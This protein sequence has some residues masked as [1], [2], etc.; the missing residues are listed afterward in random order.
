MGP[1]IDL[2]TLPVDPDGKYLCANCGGLIATESQRIAIKGEREQS[3]RNPSGY[4]HLIGYFQEASG[5]IAIGEPTAE[6]TWFE[7]Y[8]YVF[9]LCTACGNHLGWHYRKPGKAQFYGLVLNRLRLA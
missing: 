8:E 9:A 4:H 3:F 7:G 5:C 1:D 2:Q 6:F